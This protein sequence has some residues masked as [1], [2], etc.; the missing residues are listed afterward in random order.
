MSE[1]FWLV[2]SPQGHAPTVPHATEGA[3]QCE[4]ERLA[5]SNPGKEFYTLRALELFKAFK[6]VQRTPLSDVPF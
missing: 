1:T 6:P 2:W 3:A 5:A 4:A